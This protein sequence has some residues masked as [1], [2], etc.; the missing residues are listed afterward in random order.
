MIGKAIKQIRERRKLTQD[1]LA[2]LLGVSRQAICM[3][4]AS[5]RELKASMLNKLAKILKV[6]V[7]DIVSSQEVMLIGKRC[8]KPN[9]REEKMAKSK[10]SF[11]QTSKAAEKTV[12]FKVMAPNASKVLLAADFTSWDKKSIPMR[13]EKNGLWKTE[14]S[15][16]P[17][18]YQ[19]KFIVD[20]QWWNDPDNS[21]KIAN[22]LGSVNS[23]KEV[24]L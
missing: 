10:M 11:S 17:G 5:K 1:D 22:A 19:Y 4:E 21:A 8:K 18:K 14:V 6:S 23:L 20:G 16:K 7:D 2:K 13:K 9:G 12:D 3:W 15:L 24:T